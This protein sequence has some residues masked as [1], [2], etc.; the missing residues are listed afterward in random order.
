[1]VFRTKDNFSI[2]ALVLVASV[3]VDAATSTQT[4]TEAATF[5]IFYDSTWMEFVAI[6]PDPSATSVPDV[7]VNTDLLTAT[8]SITGITTGTAAQTTTDSASL[9]TATTADTL[10]TATGTSKVTKTVTTASTSLSK[11]TTSEL[12]GSGAWGKMLAGVADLD[13][14]CITNL[15][16]QLVDEGDVCERMC[17]PDEINNGIQ[18]GSIRSFSVYP[19]SVLSSLLDP[20]LRIQ[21]YQR[22]N[23]TTQEELP[24]PSAVTVAAIAIIVSGIVIALTI[25]TA[26]V[27]TSKQYQQERRQRK[28]Q[29]YSHN[30]F[31]RASNSL[32]RQQLIPPVETWGSQKPVKPAPKNAN[33]QVRSSSETVADKYVYHFPPSGPASSLHFQ[34]S[35]ASEVAAATNVKQT[36]P[37]RI[38]KTLLP[39][40]PPS[41]DRK[42][43]KRDLIDSQPAP[44]AAATAAAAV[45]IAEKFGPQTRVMRQAA[46]LPF[47]DSSHVSEQVDIH[48]SRL[49]P[50]TRSSINV[51]VDWDSMISPNLDPVSANPAVAAKVAGSSDDTARR[52]SAVQNTGNS[53]E[54]VTSSVF[55]F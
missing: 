13:C 18:C 52:T 3:C 37:Q 21:I 8:A 17:A 12:K 19:L 2:L 35:I 39:Q 16:T 50:M 53:R 30:E 6:I 40:I 5:K 14:A 49:L 46:R 48:G 51:S 31:E 24:T 10:T 42:I 54:T 23:S 47:R 11:T 7:T 26:V 34:P 55:S 43:I 33:D 1:M 25:Y 22:D 29:K 15:L 28:R 4:S 45:I 41:F 36:T 20:V 32:S 9:T 27:C 38:P 44:T